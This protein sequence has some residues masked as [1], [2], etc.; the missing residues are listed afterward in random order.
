M[1]QHQRPSSLEGF[2]ELVNSALFDIEE[3]RHSA[4]YD[5]EDFEALPGY[6]LSLEQQLGAVRRH[7]ESG[8]YPFADQDLPFM[9]IVNNQPDHSL[10]I[11]HVL[12]LINETHRKGLAEA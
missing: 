9:A 6:I 3:L 1:L 10:P 12:R 5:L 11:K 7:I 2:L 4:E 8:D